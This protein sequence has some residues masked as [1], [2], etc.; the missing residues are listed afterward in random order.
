MT[1]PG[2]A[3]L[4]VG[5]IGLGKHGARYLTHLRADVPGLRVAALSRRDAARGVAVA[6]DV[7]ATFHAEHAA[8]IA[9]PAVAAVIAVVPPTEH[10]AIV[11]AAVRAGKPLLIEKP[12]AASLADGIAQRDLLEASGVPCMVAHTLRY[13]AVVRELRRHLPALGRLHQ[14]VLG[15]SFEPTRLGWLDDPAQSG[16]GNVLHTGVHMFDLLRHLSGGEVTRLGCN[17]TRVTTRATEDSF[18]ASMEVDLGDGPPLLAAV[19]GS[20]T[21]ASRYGEV[22]VIGEHGQLAADHVHGTVVEIKDRIATTLARTPDEPTVLAVL[23][24]FEQVARGAAPPPITA[25]DGLEAVA[26]ADACYRSASCG[27][28]VPVWPRE[29]TGVEPK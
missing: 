6:R 20:R 22:R 23:R 24:D 26:I 17:T 4:P 25:S 16:G 12:F 28:F 2:K 15:Q 5:L 7:G 3:P 10:R 8:L 1:L 14:M 21:T 13:S 11:E 19:S 9:D 29:E 18:A 27:R